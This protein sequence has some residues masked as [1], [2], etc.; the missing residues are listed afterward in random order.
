MLGV[1]RMTIYR[2]RLEYGLLDHATENI[3]DGE[4]QTVLLHLRQELPALGETMV[5]GRL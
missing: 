2:R 1:S 4:L 3:S 5:W